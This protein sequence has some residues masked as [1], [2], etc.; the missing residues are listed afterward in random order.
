[1]WAMT[2]P[3]ERR[4]IK[5]SAR[6]H[7]RVHEMADRMEV[8]AGRVVE[9]LLDAVHVPLSEIQRQRWEAAA[10]AAGVP[11]AEW[12]VLRVEAAAEFGHDPGAMGVALDYLRSISAHLGVMLQRSETV[13]PTQRGTSE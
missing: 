11:L 5:V 13:P 4:T 3:N 1:M 8:G 10:R 9:H 6:V 7:H 2:S 12:I